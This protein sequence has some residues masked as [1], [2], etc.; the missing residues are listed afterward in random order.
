MPRERGHEYGIGVVVVEVWKRAVTA[1]RDEVI[2]SMGIDIP[3]DRS[4]E[5]VVNLEYPLPQ[6]GL[7][8]RP[9]VSHSPPSDAIQD[10]A[11]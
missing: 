3:S 4:H 5:D 6:D 10:K 1:K 7:P 8:T 11:L 2:A 9:D